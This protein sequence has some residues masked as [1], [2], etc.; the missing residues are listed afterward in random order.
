MLES[1]HRARAAR[2]ASAAAALLTEDVV[3]VMPSSFRPEPVVG[4]AAVAEGLTTGV[5]RYFDPES[6]CRRIVRTTIEGNVAVVEQELTARTHAG[7]PYANV[8]VWIYEF[9]GERI[10]RMIEHADTLRAARAFG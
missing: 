2:D 10:C 4:R 5:S 3:H 9:R 8:Y 6:L 7:R 1:L